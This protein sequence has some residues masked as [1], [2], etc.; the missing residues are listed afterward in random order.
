MAA[1]PLQDRKGSCASRP[2]FGLEAL[3]QRL[4]SYGGLVSNKDEV[5]RTRHQD[6]FD[7]V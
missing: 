5:Q 4:P 3:S 1:A 2:L 6:L 7:I